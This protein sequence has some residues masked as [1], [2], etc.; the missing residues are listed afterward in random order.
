MSIP[1]AKK[2]IRPLFGSVILAC[3]MGACNRKAGPPTD[4]GS[5]G[6]ATDLTR[7]DAQTLCLQRNGKVLPGYFPMG[8][9]GGLPFQPL[10]MG[11]NLYHDHCENGN[12]A[13]GT[14]LTL[15]AEDPLGMRYICR[16]DPAGALGSRFV[17]ARNKG[18][19][20]IVTGRYGALPMALDPEGQPGK[21]RDGKTLLD[22]FHAGTRRYLMDFAAAMGSTWGGP[23]SPLAEQTV[24]WGMD[25]EWEGKANYSRYARTAFASWLEKAYDGKIA[26]L[27]TAWGT[28][29]S[30]FSAAAMGPLPGEKDYASK[31]APFLDLYHFETDA[32]VRL[33]ADMAGTVHEADPAKRP[34]L[35]KTT[36]QTIEM[37]AANR[38][39]LFDHSEFADLIR[40]ISGGLYAIDIYGAGDREEYECNYI[41]NC[42]RPPDRAP[43][44]GVMLS[45]ANNHGG[46]AQEFAG[47]YWRVL[48][49]GVKA[50]DF[51]TL[52]F[53]GARDDW[54][55][56]GFTDAKTG[57]PKAKLF[58]AA[59]WAHMVHRSE[60]FWTESV[61]AEDSP[62]IA[63]L[64]PRRD[65]LLA[66]SSQ[67][68]SQASIWAYAENHRWMLY[69]RLR[70]QG[71]WVDV[72]PYTKLTPD[73]LS[74]YQALFLVGAE[75]LTDSERKTIGDYVAQGG[76]LVADERPGYYDGHHRPAVPNGLEKVL[77]IRLPGSTDGTPAFT[78]DMDGHAVEGG[79]RVRVTPDQ[80]RIIAGTAETPDAIANEFGKG[81]SLYFPFALGR[82]TNSRASGE[83]NS[84]QADG[85]TAGREVYLSHPQEFVIGEWMGKLLARIGLRPG[86][87][88]SPDNRKI[89]G[90][91]RVEEPY[92]D[93]GGN[94]AL[95]IGNRAQ[96]ENEPLPPLTLRVHLPDGNWTS[97]LWAPAENDGLNRI[98][99]KRIERG[100]YEISLPR[101]ETAGVCY[102]FNN[103][104]PLLGI[105][106][107]QTGARAVDGVSPVAKPGI[108]FTMMVQ[109]CNTTGN[110]VSPGELRAAVPPAWTV[111][112]SVVRTKSLEC[113]GV[114][115]A[116][117]RVTPPADDPETK[118]DWL[119]P[120][121]VRWNDGTGDKSIIS[122]NVEVAANPAFLLTSNTAY[123]AEYPFKIPTGATYRWI[124]PADGGAKD[125][126]AESQTHPANTALVNGFGWTGRD[127][128][129]MSAV[130]EGGFYAKVNAP[131]A[132]VVFDLKTPR[133]LSRLNV[134]LGPGKVLPDSVVAMVGNDG[135]N[136]SGPV[137]LR[138]AGS[139]LELTSA[140]SGQTGRYVKLRFQWPQAG[141]TVDEIEIWGK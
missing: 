85:P 95:L 137:P 91:L 133:S 37:P 16:M 101:I 38:R 30:D 58:Y 9:V 3:L 1:P 78:L 63:M 44:Y 6:P 99:V 17:A 36:Q 103:H 107:I 52:G 29:Y 106:T 131:V 112:P 121:V 7:P 90:L 108:P 139:V 28:S 32:F 127:G 69:R 72:I 57:K 48:G 23:R 100:L 13:D 40:P 11:Y 62:R 18:E 31:P 4:G 10:G 55:L 109:L 132:E 64:L 65:I 97:A 80:G 126:L 22:I 87:D 20:G 120:L 130:N 104:A 140:I 116:S 82:L 45:E 93:A 66:N 94:C 53:P 138:F 71:Y 51:F 122:T 68:D 26:G 134:V 15:P 61:P 81:R 35:L 67:Q 39:F 136:Y 141:G 83:D 8:Y 34:V 41:Y 118:P 115:T 43:G 124:I 119:Y 77:G 14:P 12:F 102:L 89:M 75:H 79:R 88:V 128:S 19:T 110:T 84:V 2:Y 60:Q 25:N 5:A 74:A 123:P 114:T 73:Y 113:D 59:R 98:D 86:Y 117:F 135:T 47:T 21:A 70:E 49:N 111:E 56:Y 105:D 46:P 42:I 96:A 129:R 50:M 33:M 54:D 27:N 24:F 76:V 125:P 92:V